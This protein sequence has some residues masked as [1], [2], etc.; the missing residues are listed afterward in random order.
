MRT[1]SSHVRAIKR[2]FSQLTLVRLIF[3]LTAFQEPSSVDDQVCS[4]HVLI[5]PLAKQQV[6]GATDRDESK[7]ALSII[8]GSTWSS[9]RNAPTF[10]ESVVMR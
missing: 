8:D 4:G 7:D 6:F 10:S 9:E 2:L 3:T 5:L 1:L